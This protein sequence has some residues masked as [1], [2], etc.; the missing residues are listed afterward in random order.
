MLEGVH[1][2]LPPFETFPTDFFITVWDMAP[3]DILTWLA[4]LEVSCYLQ[5]LREMGLSVK[6][7]TRESSIPI[8]GLYDMANLSIKKALVN[9]AITNKVLQKLN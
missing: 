4:S 2:P 6:E 8:N 3:C 7:W 9:F 1:D 5:T